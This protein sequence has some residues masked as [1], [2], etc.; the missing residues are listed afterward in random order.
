MQII[1]TISNHYLLCYKI[2]NLALKIECQI[3]NKIL[4]GVY[5]CVDSNATD[6]DPKERRS[7]TKDGVASF[8]NASARRPNTMVSPVTLMS[9]RRILPRMLR[10]IPHSAFCAVR[11][12]HTL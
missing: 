9:L 11:T 12:L 8:L 2:D 3:L 1:K 10:A 5:T 4:L 6:T 7:I